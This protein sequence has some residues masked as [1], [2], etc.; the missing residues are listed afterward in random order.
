MNN[1]T[2]V[3]QVGPESFDPAFDL[4]RRFLAEEGFGVPQEQIKLNLETFLGRT[5]YGA[6]L[7]SAAGRPIGIATVSTAISVELGRMAEI[8]D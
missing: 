3:T 1:D 6:F 2:Q 8:D 7:A 4:L 5:D